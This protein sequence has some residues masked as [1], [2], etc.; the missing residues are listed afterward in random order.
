MFIRRLLTIFATV[1]FTQQAHAQQGTDFAPLLA[2]FERCK[3]NPA[4]AAFRTSLADRF[5]NDFG[6]RRA[7][8]NANVQIVY[9]DSV[10]EGIGR[11]TSRNNNDHTVVTV[12]L[13]GMHRGLKLRRIEFLIGNENG[14]FAQSLVFDAQ[15]AV[16]TRVLG[17]DVARGARDG[18]TSDGA[19]FTLYIGKNEPGTVTCDL[20]S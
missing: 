9:P 1:L 18:K 3:D 16:V 5:R 19:G 10:A 17:A 11:A 20:S 6:T 8:V 15:R 2:G 7:R 13:N 14:M 12:P 4:F